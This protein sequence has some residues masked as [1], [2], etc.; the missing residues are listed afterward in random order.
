[1]SVNWSRRSN[2]NPSRKAPISQLD[3]KTG[4]A[5]RRGAA[6]VIL[7]LIPA[8]WWLTLAPWDFCEFGFR[9]A[10]YNVVATVIAI[11]VV[12]FLLSDKSTKEKGQLTAL[13]FGSALF[14]LTLLEAPVFLFG[15]N[16]QQV[17]RM[18]SNNTALNLSEGVNKPDPILIHVHWPHSSFSGE[19]AGNLVQLGIPTKTRYRAD[20]RYDR[21]GFRNSRDLERADIVVIGDSFVEAAT[22]RQDR[23]LAALLESRLGAPTAN[24]G[25]I[26][27][28]LRQELE[29]LKRFALPLSPKLIVWVLFGGN[30]LRDVEYYERQLSRFGKPTPP[31]PLTERLF[32]RNALFAGRD[33]IDNTMRV[34]LQCPPKEKALHR[35][36]IFRRSDGVTE[37]VFFGQSTDPWTPHQWEVAV[38]TL[39]EAKRLAAESGAEFVLVFVPRKYRVY[40]NHITV[41]PNHAISRWKLT[42]LPHEL[43]EWSR[44]NGIA[45]IDTTPFLEAQI[46]KGVHPYFVDDV[47]W[48]ELGHDTAARAVIDYL[49]AQRMFPFRS[50]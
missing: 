34:S 47:H 49:S 4:R 20:V 11:V 40:R 32:L 12:Y 44:Q 48:N 45:F 41:S 29:V 46:A 6:A 8:M 26:A 43:G 22:I 7:A 39:K 31:I 30:D 23:T 35:S 9:R 25:Q 19:V 18:A 1:M 42:S 5:L 3:T 36:G 24:L 2:E 10:V 37:Q 17:F 21:N 13:V 50:R 14:C 28:G 33:L 16:Y 27:Y 15:F 38:D